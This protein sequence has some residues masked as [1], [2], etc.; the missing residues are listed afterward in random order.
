MAAPPPARWETSAVLRRVKQ[1]ALDKDPVE[2]PAD[3][4]PFE[5]VM[6]ELAAALD[7]LADEANAISDAEDPVEH[8]D[9]V[10]R[11]VLGLAGTDDRIAEA[12]V[13]PRHD[14]A[15]QRAF[16]VAEQDHARHVGLV[17]GAMDESLVEHDGLA[18][19]PEIGLAVDEDAA[20]FRIRRDQ[21]EVVTQRT[22]EWIAVGTELAARRQQGKHRRVDRGNRLHE[23]DG[24]RT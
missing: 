10:P 14:A 22:G 20:S 17:L 6:R 24:P 7:A 5:C 12:A 8:A 15:R 18:V 4:Q 21:A 23:L 16:D 13:Q 11:S 1:T 3:D 9:A 19:A 2:Q